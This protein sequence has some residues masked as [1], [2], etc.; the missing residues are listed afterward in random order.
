MRSTTILAVR[1]K[2]T[3]ALGGDGQVTLGNVVNGKTEVG[4]RFSQPSPRFIANN[5]V[6]EYAS[7]G[8]EEKSLE[9]RKG[10]EIY[11]S[12]PAQPALSE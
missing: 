10:G 8:M 12:A 3:V 4:L 5:A 11:V 9:F 2:G 6:R 1:H 7:Q